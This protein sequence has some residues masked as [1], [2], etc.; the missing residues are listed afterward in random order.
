MQCIWNR[1]IIFSGACIGGDKGKMK[2]IFV[3]ILSIV[4]AMILLVNEGWNFCLFEEWNII[5]DTRFSSLNLDQPV[6]LLPVNYRS[7]L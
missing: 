3:F 1:F 4:G 6:D 7:Q 2:L 5:E